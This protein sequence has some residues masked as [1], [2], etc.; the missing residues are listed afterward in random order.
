[1]RALYNHA[2]FAQMFF[3]SIKRLSGHFAFCHLSAFLVHQCMLD[4]ISAAMSIALVALVVFLVLHIRTGVETQIGKIY[5]AL[6]IMLI[7]WA[8]ARVF[9]ITKDLLNK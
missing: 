3:L 2:G 5:L 1:M 7:V 9:T 8:G 6:Y 4:G